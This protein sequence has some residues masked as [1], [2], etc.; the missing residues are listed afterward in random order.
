MWLFV[1]VIFEA[2]IIKFHISQ[3]LEEHV[4]LQ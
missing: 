3:L 2:N 4:C 1:N